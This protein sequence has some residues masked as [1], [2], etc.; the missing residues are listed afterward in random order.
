MVGADYRL[1]GFIPQ[2]R[3]FIVAFLLIALLFCVAVAAYHDKTPLAGV[4]DKIISVSAAIAGY[5]FGS[6]RNRGGGIAP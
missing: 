5:I 6:S 1:D 3:M 4:I 2:H